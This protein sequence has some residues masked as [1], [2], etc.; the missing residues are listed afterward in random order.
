[1]SLGKSVGR[2]K[3]S[4]VVDEVLREFGSLID[5]RPEVSRDLDDFGCAIRQLDDLIEAK[6]QNL[7]RVASSRVEVRFDEKNFVFVVGRKKS[8]VR[9]CVDFV[10]LEISSIENDSNVESRGK[11]LRSEFDAIRRRQNDETF[12]VQ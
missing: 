2:K 12:L 6:R 5:L 8:V 4:Q 1:M 9:R 10:R 7:S 11:I 3:I